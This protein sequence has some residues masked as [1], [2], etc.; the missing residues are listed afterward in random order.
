MDTF[1]APFLEED[2]KK[3]T[4]VSFSDAKENINRIMDEWGFVVVTDILSDDEIKEGEDLIYE[5]LLSAVKDKHI[6]HAEMKKQFDL[7]KEGKAEFPQRSI[8]GIV[9]KGFVSKAGIPQ[10]R[11]AW[12]FRTDEK[13]KKLFEFLHDTDDLCVGTDV[14][15]FDSRKA[16]DKAINL[17]PHAD[18]DT[19]FKVGSDRSY[20]G[21]LYLWD[22]T[23]EKGSNTIVLPK[24]WNNEYNELH[25]IFKDTKVKEHSHYIRDIKDDEKRKNMMDRF[26]KGARRVPVPKGGM[27]IFNSRTIH[28]GY[29][30]GRRLAVPISWEPKK[31]RTEECLKLKLQAVNM[32]IAT[33]HWAS[34]GIHHGASFGKFY[35]PKYTGQLHATVFPMKN[36]K[37]EPVYE[38]I[39]DWQLIKKMSM[40]RLQKN[41]KPEYLKYL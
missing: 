17:W 30:N 32:G 21:I 3:Q 16:E 36:I 39:V 15:F 14:V 19:D 7:I 23:T 8:P 33:T 25:N 26:I 10:G 22:A 28:Q 27:I 6:T 41:I 13:V 24:S 11:F 31:F 18:Q 9:G 1:T 5:D 35:P 12:R 29:P 37:P 34:L 38:H 4:T 2:I 20:Q 40:D